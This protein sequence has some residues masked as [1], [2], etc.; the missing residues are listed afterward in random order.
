MGDSP[1]IA[2]SCAQWQRSRCALELRL[3]HFLDHQYDLWPHE[4]TPQARWELDT[5]ALRF[6]Q[7]EQALRDKLVVTEM[8]KVP[9]DNVV[10]DDGVGYEVP[11][12]HAQTSINALRNLLSGDLLLHDER[13]VLIHPVDLPAKAI[14][15]RARPGAL[16]PDEDQ[17]THRTDASIA[18][19]RDQGPVGP[20][21]GFLSPTREPVRT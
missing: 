12:G 4:C 14:A 10:T 6:P 11:R 13:L 8:Y 3:E 9:K 1:L 19:A 5:R 18:F 20:D 21:G 16:A 17:G 15:R 2:K 7:G